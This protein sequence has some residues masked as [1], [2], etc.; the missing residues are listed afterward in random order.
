[1]DEP[2]SSI[3]Q[4][5][6]RTVFLVTVSALVTACLVLIA[7]DWIAVRSSISRN[8]ET[9]AKLIGINL[10]ES[11]TFYDPISA[12]ELLESLSAANRVDAAVVFDDKGRPFAK[13]V[14]S[15]VMST[16]APPEIPTVGQTFDGGTFELTR[17]IASNGGRLGTI[18]IRS[19]TAELSERI[20]RYAFVVG[21]LTLAMAAVTWAMS[22]RLRRQIADPLTDIANASAAIAEGDLSC[23]APTTTGGEIGKLANTFNAMTAT[24]RDIV[25]RVRQSLGDVNEVSDS[26]RDNVRGMSVEAQ[27]QS[28]AVDETTESIEQLGGS[29]I[30][31]NSIVS[32]VS[33][34]A[35]ETSSSIVQMD[36]SIVS[37]AENM[38]HLAAAIETTSAG[39]IQVAS[40]TE[41]VV[42]GVG[43]L[44]DATDDSMERLGQLRRSVHQ[45]RENSRA[46]HTL[47]DDTSNETARGME[48][49]NET[50][51]AMNEIATSFGDLEESVSRLAKNS[52]SIGDI[53]DVI[54][55]VAEQTGMLSLNASIIAAQAGEQGKAF[56]VVADEV[57]NLAG[58]THRSTQE[59]AKLVQA[60]QDD[61]AAAVAAA[62]RGSAVVEKGVKRSN[63][64]GQVLARI[65]EKSRDSA[66]RVG[67]IHEASS[68]QSADLEKVE[69]S[70]TQVRE[71]VEQINHS[72]LDQ[73]AATSEI[74]NAVENIRS[75]GKGVKTSTDEQRRGSRLMT[76]AVTH[77]ATTLDQIAEATRAQAKSSEII[78]QALRVFRDVAGDSLRRAEAI[79]SMVETL[80]ERSTRLGDAV[81]RFGTRNTHPGIDDASRRLRDEA[82]LLSAIDHGTAADLEPPG[83]LGEV[84]T[85]GL[86]E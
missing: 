27:R 51:A 73:Q 56:S 22:A 84:S 66:E 34:S 50:I 48:A 42:S 81:G 24:L 57:N 33:D 76:D 15:D 67:V 31:V 38:D 29:I 43:T 37:V 19:N 65:G 72:S 12:Q 79:G 23:T 62:E 46:S 7:F 18:Y 45:V 35:R 36:T 78:Q 9:I 82:V 47:C 17:E 41:Q 85:A 70:M 40:G 80:S 14:K 74:A 11:L 60:V 58:R 26:L 39:V 8:T 77:V 68:Q 83:D 75:L 2:N 71:I 55:D 52:N 20:Q 13:Y 86:E 28:A 16:F 59:I 49:M 25:Q 53:L 21:L 10:V 3:H 61:T 5:L 44:K 69:R 4:R 30:E 54:R 6:T 32:E 63:V 64:A 1:M